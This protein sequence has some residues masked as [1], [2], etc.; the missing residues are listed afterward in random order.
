MTMTAK[1]HVIVVGA[2]I[3][4]ASIAWHL[5]RKGAAVTIIGEE[6][7]GVATPCSFAWINASWG[8]PEFYFHFRRRAMAEWKRLARE[9]PGLPLAWCGGLCWDM[10]PADLEAYADEHGRW[11]YGITRLNREESALL[12]PGLGEYPDFALHVAEEGAVE[13]VA[14]A[15]LLLADAGAHGATFVHA[16][17]NG[18]LQ[19]GGRIIGVVTSEGMLEADHVVLA[20]GAGAVP[21]A[22]SAGI[23]LPL[24]TPPGLIVHSRPVSKRLNGLVMTPRLHMRQTAEGRII[25]GTDFGGG[26]PGEDH[27]ASAA[28]LFARVKATIIDNGDLKFDFFTIG[29]R[30]TPADGFPI[31]GNAGL[32][33]LYAA[34]MHSG[35]TLAPLA[36]LLAA[37]ELLSGKSD[38]SLMPFRFQ[39]FADA[40]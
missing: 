36:G 5:T 23:T 21:I 27:Q 26:D 4:G 32:P 17:V 8:N 30:P 16:T 22:A 34:V 3:I 29:Y 24:S 38:E 11:G 39:R 14:A 2:G 35:V 1:P 9:L 18:L 13:P 40:E 33:G 20:A 10:P 12:E 15:C 37:D 6:L 31:I 7:G 28:E 25:A 19:N